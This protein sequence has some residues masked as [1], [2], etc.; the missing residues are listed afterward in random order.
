MIERMKSVMRM[1]LLFL[2]GGIVVPI[3]S[4]QGGIHITGETP[5]DSVLLIPE[6]KAVL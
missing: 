6:A 4:Q 2:V 1:A 3:Y 5:I